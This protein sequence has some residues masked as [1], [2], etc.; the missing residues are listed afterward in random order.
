MSLFNIEAEQS[1]LGAIL[2]EPTSIL[3][4]NEVNFSSSDFFRKE[5]QVIYN[6]M[7]KLSLENC[8]IDTIT[9][10]NELKNI[11]ML[12]KVGGILYLTSLATIVPTS[13]NISYYMKIVKDLSTKRVVYNMLRHT[14]QNIKSF[15]T[16]DLVKF[17]ED[18]KTTILDSVNV[19]DLFIDA[20]TIP[21][22]LDNNGSIFTGFSYLD[23]IVGG[24]LKFGSLSI[25]TGEPSS[26]KSTLINQIIANALSI[27]YNSFLYSGELTYQMLMGWFTKTVAN[28]EDLTKQK[29]S[30][31]EYIQVTKEGWDAICNWV[32]D[33]FFIYSKDARADERNLSNVIEYLAVKK[34]VKLFVLDNLMTLECSG[35]DKYEKQINAVKALKDLAKKYDLAI[36]LVAHPNKSSTFN[37]EAHVFEISGASEIPNLADYIFKMNR[38][39]EFTQIL[40]LKNRINGIQKKGMKVEFNSARKRFFSSS[41][42]ELKKDFGYNPVWEQSSFY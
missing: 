31:G 13:S 33:K 18:L 26:G 27:G 14:E 32:K 35:S 24:G 15:N 39:K 3:E 7:K 41:R 38:E 19:E 8:E 22:H 23:S 25:L 12:E 10:S 42:D 34:H 9:L 17:S 2:I 16:D 21:M 11:N 37:R 6:S 36:I 30:F 28:A 20:S 40:V 4:A 29:N 1:I 5:H